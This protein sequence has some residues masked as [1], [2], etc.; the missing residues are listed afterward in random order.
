MSVVG[1]G[2]DIV[3]INRI[4]RLWE[5]Y[6]VK[7]SQRVLSVEERSKLEG[8]TKPVAFIA[9]RFAAKEALAKALGIGFQ[10]NGILLSEISVK[11]DALGCPYIECNGRALLELNK[12]VVTKIHLS[13]S[14]EQEYALAFIIL[15]KD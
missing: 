13:M 1:I 2:S 15:S 5:K 7:F 9:K 8:T 3:S 14:D 12:R 6:P 4:R 11:N 10:P